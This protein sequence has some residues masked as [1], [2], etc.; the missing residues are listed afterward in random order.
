VAP[1]LQHIG[2][3]CDALFTDFDNDDETDLVL[4][5]EWMPVTFFKYR[6]GKFKNVTDST[7]IGNRRGWWSSIV[8]GDFRHTGRIDYI[9]GN[10][11]LN[12]LYQAT[13]EH[14]V[15][16]TAADFAGNGGYLA[17]P[18]LYLPGKD[19]D[20]KECPAGGRDDIV[21]RWPAL[22]KK[23]GQYK[24]FAAAAMDDI[25]PADKR[26]NALRLQANMLQTCFLRNDGNGK[27]TMMPLPAAAQVSV[28]NGMVA[29]DFD[30]DGHLDVLMNGNDFGTDI[31]IGRYDALNGLLLKG[32]GKGTFY[33]LSI[34]QSGIYIPGN[35]KALVKL[36]GSQGN[37]L[38]AATQNRNNIKIFE[39]RR[40]TQLVKAD[41][42]DRMAIIHF[43]DGKI[44]KEEFYHGSSFLS[45]SS[46]F[47][48]V[49][50]SVSAVDITDNSGNTKKI[51]F[52]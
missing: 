30:G 33:P 6:N 40:R 48:S 32:D 43:K 31:S 23:Y 10:V 37:Y 12:T 19:G 8:A 50:P 24:T 25:I 5:G 28:I 14:P 13:D 21:E 45:Q 17:I 18:S 11:G 46:L 29:D 7:G 3:V 1:E 2:L 20:L 16:I 52:H 4:T 27:F 51:V 49:T 26:A 36:A 38:V 34:R 35:G 39:L 22:K 9:V 41:R 44:R 15:C 47:I 42:N